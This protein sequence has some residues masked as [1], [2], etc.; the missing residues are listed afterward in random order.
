MRG[1]LRRVALAGA[2]L[3]AGCGEQKAAAPPAGG[4]SERGRQVYQAYCT[5]CHSPDPAQDGPVGPAVK[6]ASRELLDA[7][8]V[9]GTYPPGYRPKRPSAVMQPLPQLAPE[10]PNLA[11]FLR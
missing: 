5:S 9:Q 6:G 11:A 1:W 4:D 2:L 7:R 8:V 3:A 10:I